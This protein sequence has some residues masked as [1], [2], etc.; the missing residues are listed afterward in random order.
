MT[1]K[2]LEPGVYRLTR[3]VDAPLKD[4]RV[5]YDWR[6]VDVVAGTLFAV[7]KRNAWN[8]RDEPCPYL[9][10]CPL[11]GAWTHQAFDVRHPQAAALV[12]AFETADMRTLPASDFLRFIEAENY[13]EELFDLVVERGKLTL[14]EFPEMLAECMRRIDEKGDVT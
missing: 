13:L 1:Q 7:R 5:K 6:Y 9:E 11:R 14:D 4:R 3:N 10:V 2:E 12:S 8:S